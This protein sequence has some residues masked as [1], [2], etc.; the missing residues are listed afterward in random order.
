MRLLF[1]VLNLLRPRAPLVVTVTGEPA[2]SD[3]NHLNRDVDESES[4]DAVSH[5]VSH[6]VDES[7]DAVSTSTTEAISEWPS[8]DEFP[9]SRPKMVGNFPAGSMGCQSYSDWLE[10][11]PIFAYMSFKDTLLSQAE[12]SDPVIIEIREQ[13]EEYRREGRKVIQS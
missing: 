10:R 7:K 4:N 5:S 13:D 3:P 8:E 12:R 6:N 11:R 9:T 1:L 2:A